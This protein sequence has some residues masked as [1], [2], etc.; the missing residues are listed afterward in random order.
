MN[1]LHIE[2]WTLATAFEEDGSKYRVIEDKQK[3]RPKSWS[4]GKVRW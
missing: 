4:A 1:E 3:Q 2:D